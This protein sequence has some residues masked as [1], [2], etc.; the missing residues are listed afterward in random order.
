MKFRTIVKPILCFSILVALL[1]PMTV[2][3]AVD[4]P[5]PSGDQSIVPVSWPAGAEIYYA[6]DQPSGQVMPSTGTGNGFQLEGNWW[7]VC[8]TSNGVWYV[9]NLPHMNATTAPTFTAPRINLPT[10]SPAGGAPPWVFT[11]LLVGTIIAV[12]VIPSWEALKSKRKRAMQATIGGVIL[13][14]VSS[15]LEKNFPSFG[16]WC[17]PTTPLC[18]PTEGLAL[19]GAVVNAAT[20]IFI[21]LLILGV[22]EETHKIKEQATE[23]GSWLDVE[24]KIQELRD[25]GIKLRLFNPIGKGDEYE[26]TYQVLERDLPKD[27]SLIALWFLIAAFIVWETGV[28]LGFQLPGVSWLFQRPWSWQH[29]IWLPF[30]GA[31]IVQ[32]RETSRELEINPAVIIV[33]TVLTVGLGV[34]LAPWIPGLFGLGIFV[35]FLILLK[36]RSWNQGIGDATLLVILT[37]S[38]LYSWGFTWIIWQNPYATPWWSPLANLF[39]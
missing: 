24:G 13:L 21:T 25:K 30:F 6:I 36:R 5:P 38:L 37:I 2:A 33:Y 8:N 39:K 29:L 34:I 4:C 23:K 19:T 18:T 27:L 7:T 16:I 20:L 28:F 3:Y 11:T 12:V 26:R 10:A 31:W 1:W 17:I 35:L 15:W 32:L 22:A 9:L 14:V